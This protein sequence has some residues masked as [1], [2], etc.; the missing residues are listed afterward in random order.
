LIVDYTRRGHATDNAN[1]KKDAWAAVTKD[2]NAA[3]DISLDLQQLQNQKA[4]IRKVYQDFKF[5]LD[6]LATPKL[7]RSCA[8][9]IQNN[10]L[11][12][13]RG[14]LSPCLT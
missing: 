12:S 9:P 2:L 5:L 3:F 1:L 10:T 14:N 11:T 6:H 4:A 8:Q 7:G 13:S